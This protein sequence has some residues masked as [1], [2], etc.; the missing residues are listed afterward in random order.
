M[1]QSTPKW[2][3]QHLSVN[4]S[5]F[6]HAS[7]GKR[8]E[9]KPADSLLVNNNLKERPRIALTHCALAKIPPS[10]TPQSSRQF[11]FVQKRFVFDH[12]SESLSRHH[13]GSKK[14][15]CGISVVTYRHC[16]L[17]ETQCTVQYY[18]CVF[19]FVLCFTYYNVVN[20]R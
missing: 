17:V 11:L 9:I 7:S 13:R 10:P 14:N 3:A 6:R 19:V 5:H 1:E 20:Y 15:E 16:L 2:H 12:Q 8:P 18:V 4:S